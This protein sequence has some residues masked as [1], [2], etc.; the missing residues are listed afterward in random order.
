MLFD[1]GMCLD[2]L[3]FSLTLTLSRWEMESTRPPCER[4]A[5]RFG[6]GAKRRDAK[7]RSGMVG[8]SPDY[9]STEEALEMTWSSVKRLQTASMAIQTARLTIEDPTFKTE[10]IVA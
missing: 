3:V 6:G 4:R 10:N 1:V 2:S 8:F 7:N 5:L 9:A